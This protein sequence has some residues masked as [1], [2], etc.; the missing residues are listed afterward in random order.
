MSTRNLQFL[1][2]LDR[3]IK[4]VGELYRD[5]IATWRGKK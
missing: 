1:F 5:L 3:R 4:P 2:D